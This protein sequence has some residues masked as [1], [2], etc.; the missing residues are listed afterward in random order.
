L[1]SAL[2]QDKTKNDKKCAGWD[3]CQPAQRID[4]FVTALE[5]GM[6]K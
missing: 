6:P 4:F 2:Q 1:G 3:K 5:T